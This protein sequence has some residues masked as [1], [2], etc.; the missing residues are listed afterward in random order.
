MSLGLSLPKS[1]HLSI[2]LQLRSGAM[3]LAVRFNALSLPKL[4]REMCAFFVAERRPEFSR[5]F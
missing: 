1:F 5:A 4:L 3:N 2:L